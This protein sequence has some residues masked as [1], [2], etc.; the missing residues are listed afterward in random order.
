[1]SLNTTRQGGNTGK[2]SKEGNIY[3]YWY[4]DCNQGRDQKPV[5]ETAGH[6]LACQG[7]LALKLF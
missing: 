2:G 3:T 5:D 4:K 1:M 7:M 6:G